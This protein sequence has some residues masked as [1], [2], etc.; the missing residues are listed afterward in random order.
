MKGFIE[1]TLHEMLSADLHI[2]EQIPP[3]ADIRGA[4]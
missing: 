3:E 2:G 4:S 1:G